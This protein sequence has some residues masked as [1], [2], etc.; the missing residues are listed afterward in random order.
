MRLIYNAKVLPVSSAP[1]DG[2]A[3]L[4][5]GTK[6]VDAGYHLGAPEGTEAIDAHGLPL[7]PGLVDAHTH[8]TTAEE[9]SLYGLYDYNEMTD[10]VTP[11]L[12]IADSIYPREKNI[13]I[14]RNQGGVTCVQTLPGSSNII[15]G[16]GAIIKLKDANT[17]EEILVRSPSCMKAALGENPIR[18]YK[19]NGKK[20]PNTRMAN[21]YVMRKAFQDAINYREK[22]AC[23]KA[24]EAFAIDL[25]MEAL[26][27]VLDRDI[28]LSIHSHRSDDICTAVRIAEEFGLD[29]T[30]EHCTEGQFIVPF[31]S[32]HHVKAAVGPSFGVA[33]KPEIRNR[34]WDTLL[35]LEKGGVHTCIITDHPVIPLYGL[36]V[37]ASLASRAGLSDASALR[38]VTLSSAEHMGMADRVGSIEKG[39]D[40]DLV[41]WSGDPLDTRSHPKLVMIDGE[42][43]FREEE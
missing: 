12:R 25:N 6:I 43:A 22:K 2:A 41:I 13:A 19:Q 26:L 37:A 36:I 9:F 24:R 11:A 30:I 7:T 14:A 33:T 21:A 18:V 34:S 42:V 4:I 1:M 15:G 8:I 28:K 16:S 23:R 3:V 10:P 38:N 5:D 27:P 31:L 17:L 20:S 40:A 39:K 35:A 32:E 29:F